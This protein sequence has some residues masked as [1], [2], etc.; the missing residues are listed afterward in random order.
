MFPHH[1]EMPSS[2]RVAK[3]KFVARIP[4]I[5]RQLTLRVKQNFLYFINGDAV[6]GNVLDS[7][8]AVSRPDPT[9]SEYRS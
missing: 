5:D 1:S 2:V 3:R 6:F 4:S 8:L 7:C 9:R